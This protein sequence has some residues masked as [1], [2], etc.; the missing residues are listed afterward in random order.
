MARMSTSTEAS[1]PRFTIQTVPPA[2]RINTLAED[3][4]EG[5][6]R[7]P[8]ELPPKYFY[9]DRGSALFD[10]ICDTPEYYP[11]RTEASLLEGYGADIVAA[12][13]PE[14]IVELGSGTSRKTDVLLGACEQAGIAPVYWPYDVCEGVL[15]ETGDRLLARFPWLQVNALVGDYTAG[16]DHLPRPAGRCLYVFLGGT[17]GNFEPEPA[18]ILLSDLTHHMDAGDGLLLGTDRV[19]ARAT[20]EAAYNDAGG[21][22]AE[23]DRNVLQVINHELNADFEP[24]AFRHEAVFNAAVGRMEMYLYADRAQTVTVGA[25]QRSYRFAEGEPIFTEISRKF[26]AD[27]LRDELAGAGLALE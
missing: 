17:L 6:A 10:R 16:L 24:S 1:M 5:F 23:F 15:Q 12:M 25:L 18:A 20:L 11:M 14:H 13:R 27:G 4:L 3:V 26:T 19:K 9:D 7:S 22:S 21:V 2:R 8:K